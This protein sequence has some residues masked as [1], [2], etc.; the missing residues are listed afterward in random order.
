MAESTQVHATGVPDTQEVSPPEPS[1]T[2]SEIIA[3]A[4]ALIPM[5]RARQDEAERLGRHTE[6]VEREFVAA[7]FYRML[8][9]RRFGGY[10]FDVPT[11]WKA[12]LAI[13]SGDPG[14]GRR[15]HP[16]HE[17]ERFQQRAGG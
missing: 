16:R 11:F 2:P 15:P 14:T 9:P 5:V 8:Q 10:E 6:A 17:R 13:S 3:R 1:L 12:M 7:G 4:H